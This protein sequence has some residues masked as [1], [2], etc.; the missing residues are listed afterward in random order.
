MVLLHGTTR[1]RAEQII[2]DGPNPNFIE[3]GVWLKSTHV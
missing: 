1:K 3:P 2:R